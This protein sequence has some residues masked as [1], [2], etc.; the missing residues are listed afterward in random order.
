MVELTEK[1]KYEMIFEV[2]V[3]KLLHFIC[4]M[5]QSVAHVYVT[6]LYIA[7]AFQRSGDMGAVAH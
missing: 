2:K 6:D 1:W 3:C 5:E 4:F 7:M